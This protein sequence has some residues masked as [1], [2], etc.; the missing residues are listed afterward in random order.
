M[1]NTRTID[2]PVHEVVEPLRQR[3]EDVLQQAKQKAAPIDAWLRTL[4][5]DQPVLA[6]AGAVGVG[7]LLGRL[8]R[9]AGR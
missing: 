5:R 8:V 6:L 4:A 9:R 3:A 2:A 1:P 7:F